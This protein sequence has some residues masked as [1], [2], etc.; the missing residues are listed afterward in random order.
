MLTPP[1]AQSA[2]TPELSAL[3]MSRL[4]LKR[5]SVTVLRLLN[6]CSTCS[7]GHERKK[8]KGGEDSEGR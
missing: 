3:P 5:I 6:S 2:Q 4:E 1:K 7:W 8:Q